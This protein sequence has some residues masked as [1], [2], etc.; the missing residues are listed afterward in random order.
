MTDEIER[1]KVVPYASTVG[2][3]IYAMLCTRPSI[4]FVVGML[5]DFNLILGKNIGEQL[6][7]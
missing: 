3:L 4:Y 1:M 5:V 7:L 2:S 6:N